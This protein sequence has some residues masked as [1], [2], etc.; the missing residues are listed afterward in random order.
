MVDPCPSDAPLPAEEEATNTLLRT[1]RRVV[2]AVLGFTVL[3][4]GLALM[5]LP[6]PALV[7]IPAGLAILALEFRW[8][9]RWLRH[10]RAYAR[11]AARSARDR[12]R[13]TDRA[14]EGA[15]RERAQ[16]QQG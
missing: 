13:P 5:V 2:V 4:I 9:R 10:V 15:P 6:G 16:Q 12:V 14:G 3:A 8:A 7:V 11:E 1:A